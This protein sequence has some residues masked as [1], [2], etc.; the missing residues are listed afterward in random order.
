[1][2]QSKW[3]I[4]F[5]ICLKHGARTI[6]TTALIDCGATGNFI[7]PS[8]VS[9]L[10]LP[11]RSIPPLQAL[12]A[13]GTQNK[14]GQIAAATWVC[15][16][17][18][19]FDNNLSLMIVGLGR[20]QIV[21]GMP[22][23]MKNNPRIDWVKKTILF[24]DEHIRKTTLST[25][26]AI[27]AQKDDVVLPPQYA[28]YAN[29]FSEWTFDALPPQ[30]D[31]N[32]AIKLKESFVPKVAKI[33][34]LNPQEVD[35][36]R[37]FIMENLKMGC[38]RP[39][40][41]L[42][43]SPF[44]FVKKKDRKL[45]PVQD[46]RYLNEHTVKNAYPLPLITDLI[47]NLR[48]FSCFTKFDIH[49]GYNNIHIKEGDEWKAAL[50][51]QLGLFE[52]TVMF[53]GLCGSPPTFQ[54]FMNY[55]I[56]DY[57]REG[58]LVIYMND[59]AI[60]ADSQED[61]EWK[62]HLVLQWFRDLGLSLK[63]STCKF[64]KTEVEFLGMIVG[65]GCI[66][67]DPA[68]LS[69]ITTWPLL[70][71]VKAVCSFLG[72]CNFYR[73]FIPN[74]SNT[75]APLTILTCKNQPWV[76]SPDQQT[77]FD[78]LLSQFQT[79]PV[80]QLPDVHRPF[81]VMTN[82]SLL[83]SG[84]VLMQKDDNGDLHPCAYLSQTFTAAKWNY[85]IY[86]R[87]LLAVI[88][89]L[90]HWCHYLQG[91]NHPVTLLT[92]HKNLTY[93]CQPQ[94]LSRCQARWMMFLQDFDLHCIHIPGSAMG[95]ADT[96]SWLVDPDI[97]SDNDNVTLL[98]DNL[99]LCVIDTALV[100]KITSSTPTDP[101]VLTTLQNLSVGSPL[102]PRSS[103]TDWRFS[104]SFLYFK[105]RLCVPPGAC[106]NLVTSVHSSLTSSHSRFFRMYSL[107][108]RDYWWLGMS[109]FV[110][111]FISGCTLCQQMKVNTHPTVPV[112]LPIPSSCHRLFQQLSVGLITDLPSSSSFDSLLV[113]V[114]H[115]LS[116]GVI[117]I[118]CTKTI[119]VKGVAKLFF[120]K[121]FLRF[122]LHDHLISDWGPQFA[123]AFAAELACI[124]G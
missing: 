18:T 61:E 66:R 34:L 63:L 9:R 36:C 84:G 115:G 122:G 26:L 64:G 4:W 7:D 2:N 114:D 12:N 22:W 30:R 3:A 98:S 101:L 43:A 11:S 27:A 112:L 73:R 86:D 47:D 41:S 52:L 53:F 55:N 58:W 104:G 8:L 77:A 110:H 68:K 107:L 76:W 62:V 93:F 50:I 74:F 25:E 90:D 81:V 57:I 103:F 38:I 87:E 82:A 113:V 37:E 105:N 54:A 33:Y 99:F 56:A 70:K 116:K 89:A 123:S 96:L 85:N 102:F 10:L 72:F 80:L 48:C 32:H 16:Q 6:V 60:G 39:L 17:A 19:A 109:S 97:S 23:L 92:D 28:D 108:S 69:A 78:L 13:D 121:V 42:Q 35:A 67:M 5:P 29:V 111:H 20:A 65:C 59:L 106:H 24:D 21:L 94:K 49:W 45:R 88:H 91:T 79:T 1:M 95:P 40:K 118:P 46:Y 14:Q 15:C 71:T 31:F 75:A 117:L 51:T 120:K 119:D 124:L 100:D 44:F 83:A